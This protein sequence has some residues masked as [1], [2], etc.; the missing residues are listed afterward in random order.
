MARRKK[1][2]D[3][4]K[5]I[6]YGHQCRFGG[7]IFARLRVTDIRQQRV[8]QTLSAYCVFYLATLGKIVGDGLGGAALAN[9]PIFGCVRFTQIAEVADAFARLVDACV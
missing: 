6:A 7:S 4:V 9:A 1:L 3:R 2:D 8:A 5:V